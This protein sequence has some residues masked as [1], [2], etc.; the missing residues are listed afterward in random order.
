MDAL[1]DIKLLGDFR[2]IYGG[3][4]LTGVDTPRL[5]SL[6]AYLLLHRDSPISRKLIAFNY[7]PDSTEAKAHNN[8]RSL[9][10]RL[11]NSLPDADEYIEHTNS[12]IHWRIESAYKLDVEQFQMVIKAANS[13]RSPDKLIISLIGLIDLYSGDLLPGCYEDWIIP[14]RDQLQSDFLSQLDKLTENLESQRKFQEAIGYAQKYLR[15]KPYQESA[16]QRMMRLHALNN[17][18]AS[19]LYAYHTCVRVLQ[20]ELGIDP[21]NETRKLYDQIL[22]S[23]TSLTKELP[24]HQAPFVGRTKSWQQLVSTWRKQS[25]GNYHPGLVLISGEAGIGKTRLAEEFI[26]WARRQ[27]ITTAS[28]NAYP[29]ERQLAYSPVISWLRTLPIKGLP[30]MWL[31]EIAR[32]APDIV[33][34]FSFETG[35]DQP[36]ENW[37]RRRIFEALKQAILFQH[38]S[39]ILFLDDA[40][41]ADRETIEWLHFLLRSEI[42]ERL[43]VILTIRRE[44][45]DPKHPLQVCL[46]DLLHRIRLLEIN[47][48]PLSQREFHD[49]TISI[50]NRELSVEVIDG[51]YH[52]SEGNPFFLEETL[53]A[54]DSK[55]LAAKPLANA[56]GSV[57]FEF[58]PKINSL[59]SARLD[60]L[61]PQ[62]RAVVN[63]AAILGRSFTGSV[64]AHAVEI[65]EDTL[66]L[67]LDELWQRQILRERGDD[68]YDFSHDLLRQAA[69]NALSSVRRRLL[70]RRAAEALKNINSTRQDENS[71][72]IAIQYDAGGLLD[73]A[74][75][76]YQHAARH[77]RK[78]FAVQEAI[79]HL[80]RGVDLIPKTTIDNN[81]AVQ[82]FIELGDLYHQSGKHNHALRVYK[83]ALE[84]L[85]ESESRIAYARIWHKIGNVEKSALRYIESDHAYETA[86]SMISS[87]YTPPMNED[88]S[89]WTDIKLD[90]L[91]LLYLQYKLD[92]MEDAIEHLSPIISTAGSP[93]QQSNFAACQV[94]LLSRQ[95]R[96]VLSEK[97]LALT[98]QALDTAMK[99]GDIYCITYKRFSLGFVM[100]WHGDLA[101]AEVNLKQAL[102][103]ARLIGHVPLQDR[104]LA[105]LCIL[106]RLQQE[107]ETLQENIKELVEVARLEGNSLY[108]GVA[109]ANLAWLAWKNGDYIQSEQLATKALGLLQTSEY[110]F[111]WLA[112]FPLMAI[113]VS[114]RD[115]LRANSLAAHALSPNQQA[116]P[117]SLSKAFQAAMDTW[118][119]KDDHTSQANYQLVLEIA[120]NLGYI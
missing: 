48:E 51:L 16:H 95:E 18:R 28:A 116:L 22:N 115:F 3:K 36:D 72:Q 88:L 112:L 8:L 60:Q 120:N 64:L 80:Q 6:L 59:L 63:I 53:R 69:I 2:L 57:I 49:L 7:W 110:P 34:D 30:T 86:F 94:M 42:R 61:A 35:H 54:A 106:Y 26:E 55:M 85:N 20:N 100:L 15:Y 105:Y 50:A 17:D 40:H 109:D 41:W 91:D 83:R 38:K 84:M 70:H 37:R 103:D 4:V 1:L 21:T 78:V 65:E 10:H 62:T 5:Q 104:C 13:I 39:I 81:Q 76:W 89:I 67:A 68:T 19:G 74:V 113:A 77:A 97:T 27:G 45:L 46:S 25:S 92:E 31:A 52:H 56:P 47:L 11:R 102:E 82:I 71:S 117:P 93:I 12:W 58:S 44:S 32:L 33:G 79:S 114:N 98:R 118:D 66:L 107:R 119:Q 14:L 99:S 75:Q 87:A 96:F 24:E 73:E 23:N 29:S 90:Q 43:L 108:L 101:G 9:L 111:Y